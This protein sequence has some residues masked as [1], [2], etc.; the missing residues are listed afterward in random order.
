MDWGEVIVICGGL[1]KGAFDVVIWSAGFF[2]KKG[3]GTYTHQTQRQTHH[4]PRFISLDKGVLP[5]HTGRSLDKHMYS[6]HTYML[7]APMSHNIP[8]TTSCNRG[9]GVSLN[10]TPYVYAT[11]S[12]WH[13]TIIL[14]SIVTR[15]HDHNANWN[16]NTISMYTFFYLVQVVHAV[17]VFIGVI[18]FFCSKNP[19]SVVNPTSHI[20]RHSYTNIAKFD[21]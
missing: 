15:L 20:L 13:I 6:L 17:T 4:P 1:T 14:H 11:Y 9:E 16:K 10:L 8:C 2:I 21:K 12:A 5:L 3:E 7:Y 19:T 18:W